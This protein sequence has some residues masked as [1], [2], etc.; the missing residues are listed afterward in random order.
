MTPPE[1]E[2]TFQ[3]HG[4]RAKFSPGITVM[5]AAQ[6]LGVDISTLCSG[7]GTC[8]K[9]K[10]RIMGDAGAGLERTESELKHLSEDEIQAGTRLACMTRLGAST[11]VYVP[12]RSR[13]GTQRLQTEGLDV[14]VEP[15]P[16]VRKY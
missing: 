2:V 6:N 8:G 12:L 14:P 1:I 11:V 7:K 15:N 5:K 9:C 3:P 13:L 10:V 4:K 16:L